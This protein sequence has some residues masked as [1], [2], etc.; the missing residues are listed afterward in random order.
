MGYCNV[1]PTLIMPVWIK[2]HAY[3][4]MLTR[5]LITSSYSE[6]SEAY[7]CAELK[8]QCILINWLI[9]IINALLII[10][11]LVY[12]QLCLQGNTSWDCVLFFA[13]FFSDSSVC[14]LI[15]EFFFSIFP[16]GKK[17]D[18]RKWKITPIKCKVSSHHSIL[19]ASLT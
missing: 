17:F 7:Y 1:S 4:F 10:Y 8:P 11:I 9:N 12:R 15:W 5:S 16:S 14:L 3:H 6:S 13:Y 2:L 19:C 18:G